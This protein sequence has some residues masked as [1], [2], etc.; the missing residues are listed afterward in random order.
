MLRSLQLKDMIN[1]ELGIE[2]ISKLINEKT[3]LT[4]LLNDQNYNNSVIVGQIIT[5]KK[6]V[7][8]KKELIVIVAFIVGFI[9]SIFLVFIMNTFRKEEDKVTA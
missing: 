6:P 1:V 5:N 9:L 8:P 4:L 7:K 3:E 2:S